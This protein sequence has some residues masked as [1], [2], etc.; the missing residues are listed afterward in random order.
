MAS[1]INPVASFASQSYTPDRLVVDSTSL[2]SRKVTILS[3][4]NLARGAVVGKITASGKYV[5]SLSAAVD[6]SQTPDGILAEPIDASGGDKEGLVHFRGRFDSTACTF[7][8]A[9][10]ADTTREGLRVKGIDL[11]SSVAA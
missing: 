3:G 8:S 1:F 9:H 4:Q 10:T 5:L 7:G 6:G 11:V 2:L